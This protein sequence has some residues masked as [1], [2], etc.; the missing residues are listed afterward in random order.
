MPLS[1]QT[2]L[3][4]SIYRLIFVSSYFSLNIRKVNIFSVF[5]FCFEEQVIRYMD[6]VG[7]LLSGVGG[8]APCPL[9]PCLTSYIWIHRNHILKSAEECSPDSQD[10]E[11]SQQEKMTL[12][13]L[14]WQNDWSKCQILQRNSPTRHPGSAA[15]HWALAVL[16]VALMSCPSSRERG[17]NMQSRSKECMS[18]IYSLLSI[19]ELFCSDSVRGTLPQLSIKGSETE[20]YDVLG[21]IAQRKKRLGDRSGVSRYSKDSRRIAPPKNLLLCWALLLPT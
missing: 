15:G 1:K 20:S 8:S 13:W 10:R 7:E 6:G 9:Q 18:I 11:Q 5:L 4:P 12:L 3:K 21:C 19:S 16:L 14:A 17:R 2:L